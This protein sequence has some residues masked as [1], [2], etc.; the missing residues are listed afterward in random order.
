[1]IPRKYLEEFAR[2]HPTLAVLL[3]LY[4]LAM[5]GFALWLVL[6]G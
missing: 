3:C 5:T 6:S 4:G 2:E 1:M